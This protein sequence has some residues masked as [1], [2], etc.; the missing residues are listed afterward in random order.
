M[1]R[2]ITGAIVVAITIACVIFLAGYSTA[3]RDILGILLF[4]VLP[5]VPIYLLRK[6][7][8][9]SVSSI[10]E[11]RREEELDPPK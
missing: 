4:S 8:E 2:S 11:R 6:K 5:S 9:R 3:N 7:Y 10:L 1:Q